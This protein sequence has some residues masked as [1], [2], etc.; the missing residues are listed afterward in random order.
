MFV[1]GDKDDRCNPA[2][3]RKMAAR[4]QA[5]DAQ[6]HTIIVDYAEQRGHHPTLPLSVR[7]EALVRRIAF[8]CSELSLSIHRGGQDEMSGV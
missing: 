2:H 1:T 4:L 3:V 7:L 6:K 8:L 5:L